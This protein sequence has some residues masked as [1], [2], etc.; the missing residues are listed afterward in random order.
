MLKTILVLLVTLVVLPLFTFYFDAHSLDAKQWEVLKLLICTMLGVAG[1]CFVTSEITKN[2]SQVDK[3]WSLVPLIYGGIVA[4]QYGFSFRVTVMFLLICLWGLRLTYNFSRRGAYTWPI[5]AGE[6]D[7]RWAILRAMPMFQSKLAWTSF[8]LF[9]ISL[10]QNTLILLFT[11]PILYASSAQ[12]QSL[13]YIEWLAVL[14]FV[15]AVVLETVADEQQWRYQTEKHRRLAANEPL[16]EA[17][18]L[19]FVNTGLWGVVRHPNY[20]AEQL[21]WIAFYLIG[22]AATGH[23]FNW[24]IAGALL[25][26]VLFQGSSDFSEK[27]SAQKYPAYKAYQNSVGRFLPKL[28]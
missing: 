27:I 5:W 4:Y 14:L 7:Y 2:C 25:L 15:V 8:N 24:S 19:G 26:L 23:W 18:K 1:L 6:E 9:F 17:Q 20:L 13:S 28:F 16:S 21:V 3:I 12:N 22:A 10:Y 11:L